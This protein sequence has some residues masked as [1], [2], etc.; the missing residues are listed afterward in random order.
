MLGQMTFAPFLSNSLRGS[1]SPDAGP[2]FCAVWRSRKDAEL[3][4]EA[5]GRAHLFPA[6]PRLSERTSCHVASIA[7]VAT[8]FLTFDACLDGRLSLTDRVAGLVGDLWPGIEAD[9]GAL[10]DHRAGLHDFWE[11]LALAGYEAG[12]VIESAD[13]RH[14]LAGIDLQ[15]AS[16]VG[17][18]AYSNTGFL[19]LADVL[20]RVWGE[21]DLDVILQRR[22][23][24][25][26]GLARTRFVERWDVPAAEEEPRAAVA[27]VRTPQ[28]F[29]EN[30]ARYAIPGPTSL[31]TTA[32]DLARLSE[33]FVRRTH[34]AV[35]AML[36]RGPEADLP[37]QQAY[38]SGLFFFRGAQGD[39]SL[40]GHRG[41]DW[42]FQASWF[43][44]LSSGRMAAVLSNASCPDFE[45]A[46]LRYFDREEPKGP[47]V[48]G[49][50]WPFTDAQTRLFGA[51][52]ALLALRPVSRDRIEVMSSAVPAEW[53]AQQAA[54]VV[55]RGGGALAFEAGQ[56]GAA[57]VFQERFTRHQLPL[58]GFAAGSPPT[59]GLYRLQDSGIHIALQADATGMVLGYGRDRHIRLALCANGGFAGEG[60]V[61][62]PGLS[63]ELKDHWCLSTQRIGQIALTPS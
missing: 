56:E 35:A 60:F 9:L 36:A 25:P 58:A 18:H 37:G 27:Y 2:G 53:Q 47:P 14:A 42:G 6:G 10:L 49:A 40:V 39:W 8:S 52:G 32:Q 48:T 22:M 62:A 26:L 51:E 41:S 34:P 38:R 57:L 15:D 4:H 17:R 3:L 21:A 54:Y 33:A 20:R 23:A 61:L 59:D 30:T 45:F 44:D 31:R 12:D 16:R 46:A 1:L 13:V 24:G 7:K 5:Q 50:R 43:T 29:V 63:A 55:A 11:L 28:G 19:I